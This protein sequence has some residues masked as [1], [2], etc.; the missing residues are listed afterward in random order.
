VSADNPL[1]MWKNQSAVPGTH[2]TQ[3]YFG[4]SFPPQTATLRRTF[5]GA[6]GKA[7]TQ[8]AI[9]KDTGIAPE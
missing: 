5:W 8:A 6:D 9:V 1:S 7:M 4:M 3:C 2:G